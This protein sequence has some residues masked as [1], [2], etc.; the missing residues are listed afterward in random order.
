[1]R[2]G[3]GGKAVN[4]RIRR[5]HGARYSV[6]IAEHSA[7][8]ALK[9][10]MGRPRGY[11]MSLRICMEAG[12][13]LTSTAQQDRALDLE[14]ERHSADDTLRFEALARELE[15]LGATLSH[16]LRAPLRS[17][18]GFSR[19]LLGAP[20]ADQLDATGQDYVQ[21][22]HRASGRLAQMMEDLLQLVRL[23]RNGIRREHVDLS[24]MALGILSGLQAA[25]PARRAEITVEPDI[26][27]TGDAALLRL[28]LENLIGN[29]WKFTRGKEVASIFFGRADGD[30]VA[31]ICVRDNG[32]GFEQKYADRLFRAF[33][34]LHSETEFEGRGIG[35]AK[36]QRAIHAH[37]GRI[38][39][40]G[41]R[42]AGAAFYFTLPGMDAEKGTHRP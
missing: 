2:G 23:A 15:A 26:A 31:A 34:R 16:D 7:P 19:L 1:M 6:G 36:A 14:S 20:Y 28:V 8:D 41:Q 29:A 40:R 24:A 27:V 11:I 5:P 13:L 39:P 4:L 18:E 10:H 30:G 17:I 22:I 33:Q 9:G 37:G 32:I 3:K 42:G 12:D 38:W 25:A 35:L 21:R